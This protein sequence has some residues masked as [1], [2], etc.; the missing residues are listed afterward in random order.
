MNDLYYNHQNDLL[1]YYLLNWSMTKNGL[2]INDIEF[3][4][5]FKYLLTDFKYQNYFKLSKFEEKNIKNIFEFELVIISRLFDNHLVRLN[6]DNQFITNYFG[7]LDSKFTTKTNHNLVLKYRKAVYDYIY[8][9]KH[10]IISRFFLKDIVL[11]Q[12]MDLIHKNSDFNDTFKIRELFNI[13]LSFNNK[14]DIN[15]K[16]FGEI[17]LPSKL[18]EYQSK[19][20]TI[21]NDDT[22]HLV[23]DDEFAF[24][25]GQLIYYLLSMNESASKSHA[26]LEPFLSK[27]DVSLLKKNISNA[28]NKYKHALEW[29][30]KVGKGRFERL[31]SEVLSYDGMRD[32]ISDYLPIL[33]SGYFSNSLLYEK[34]Q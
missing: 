24:A 10:N 11:S 20:R 19:I 30:G 15:N 4:P 22:I 3:V 32:N 17:D 5:A 13:F 23:S 25:A 2:T 14:F 33:L 1:D 18:N 26:L 7:E 8:K 12:V 21:F 29:Y 27:S 34:A 16:S 9:S 28:I 6:K 31:A